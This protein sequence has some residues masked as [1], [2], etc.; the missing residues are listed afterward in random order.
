MA[1][2]RYRVYF[3]NWNTSIAGRDDFD[4]ED[5]AQAAVIARLLRNACSDRCAGF[6]LWQGGRQVDTS[7]T[8]GVDFKELS[9][10]LQD[11]VLERELAI[12]D[13]R[14]SIADS[15]RLLE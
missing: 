9:T 14:W 3:V 4:V 5:D 2:A 13:S 11:I 12:R 15:R 8:R 6:E 1:M 10:H 7:L